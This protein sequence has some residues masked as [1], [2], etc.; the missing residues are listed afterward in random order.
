MK[1]ILII[2]P[3]SI[4]GEIILKGFKSGFDVLGHNTCLIDVRKLD[5]QS[6][7]FEPDVV[8][9]YDY[10]WL[11]SDEA[12]RTVLNLLERNSSMRIIHYFADEP[13]LKYAH[14]G[15]IS[16]I[17]KFKNFCKQYPKNIELIFW[18]K[19]YLDF[20]S[21]VK[22]S[23]FP[24][25]AD[26]SVYKNY[27]CKKKYDISFVGRPLSDVRQKILAKVVKSFGGRLK[28]FSYPKHFEKSI[29][30][31]KQYLNDSELETYEKSFCGFIE[32]P[33]ELSKIYNSTKINLNIN[34]QG[35]FS[36]NL[37]TF[38]VL[39]SEGFLLHDKRA[40]IEE[41]GLSDCLVQYENADDLIEKI[42]YYI[43]AGDERK[44]ISERAG[45]LIFERYNIIARA[46]EILNIVE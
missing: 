43:D 25:C 1:N 12:Q 24:I 9:S 33:Y 27:N 5:E 6:F 38:E 15:D 13:T 44:K 42:S 16:L 7:A 2:S 22:S 17:N 21:D 39:A 40:G 19:K 10:G 32:S 34:L 31:M 11:I 14:S 41:L 35:D 45:K 4:A 37:R 29:N 28:I 36:L 23:Y 46:G 3:I 8:L 26:C 20:C 18:D 30:D